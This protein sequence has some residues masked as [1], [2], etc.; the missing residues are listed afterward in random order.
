MGTAFSA[1]PGAGSLATQSSFL[2]FIRGG[3][4]LVIAA[5]TV[6]MEF[7]CQRRNVASSCGRY[8]CG[9]VTTLTPSPWWSFYKPIKISQQIFR[10]LVQRIFCNIFTAFQQK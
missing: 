6:V 3:A 5:G 1:G 4:G 8:F 10:S 9:A 7:D 2:S